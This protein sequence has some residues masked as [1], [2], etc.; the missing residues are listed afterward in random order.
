MFTQTK[1]IAYKVYGYLIQ[2][3]KDRQYVSMYH[4]SLTEHTKN[5]LQSA[6]KGDNKLRCLV[7]T[8]AFGMVRSFIMCA[9]M[10]S[11]A[12]YTVYRA[13]ISQM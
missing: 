6:F 5:Y 12:A 11:L 13:W 3:A 10:G 9:C 1:N 4:A 7:A 2:A 8:I